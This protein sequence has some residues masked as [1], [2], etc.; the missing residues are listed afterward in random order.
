M[1][2]AQALI[3]GLDLDNPIIRIRT[4]ELLTAL[5]RLQS[6]RVEALEAKL[7]AL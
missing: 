4:W 2:S 1:P 5:E 6:A 3:A 7:A